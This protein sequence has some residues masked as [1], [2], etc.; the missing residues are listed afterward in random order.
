MAIATPRIN[1]TT[2]AWA[3]IKLNL[4]GRTVEGIVAIKYGVKQKK[5]N[6]YGRGNE[7]VN[8]GRGNKEYEA[9]ITLDMQEVQAIRG[10]IP[11][12]GLPGVKP[13][14]IVVVYESETGLAVTHVLLGCEFME[15]MVDTKQGDTRIQITLPLLIAGIQGM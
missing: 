11:N 4:L 3:D 15:D 6:L 12:G 13:F 10:L 1:G 9:S 2:Y 8:V 5:E 14:P 7:P